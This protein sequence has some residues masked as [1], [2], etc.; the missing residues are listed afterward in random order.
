MNN[1]NQGLSKKQAKNLE[2]AIVLF[3]VLALFCLFQPFSMFL[4]AIACGAVVV[5]GLM[6][7]LVPLCVE[8]V[9]V[10][11]LIKIAVII[12]LILI[13]VAI[14]AIGSG[15]LYAIYLESTR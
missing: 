4:Y 11:Q 15:H 13:V 7:N 9:K 14:I 1:I 6:F 3:S 8:G 5:A 10:S 12:F 2:R